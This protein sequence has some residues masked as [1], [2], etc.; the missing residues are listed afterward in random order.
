MR[1]GG[2]GT[3][4]CQRPPDQIQLVVKE[5]KKEDEFEK[6]QIPNLLASKYEYKLPHIGIVMNMLQDLFFLLQ[7]YY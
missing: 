4:Q 3:T 6:I 5:K 2:A 7:I 1:L